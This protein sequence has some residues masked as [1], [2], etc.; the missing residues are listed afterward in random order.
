MTQLSPLNSSLSATQ[1]PRSTLRKLV[2]S[3]RTKAFL[4]PSGAWTNEIQDAAYF[5]DPLLARAAAEKFQLRDVELYY[6]FTDHVNS[7]Y[8]FTLPL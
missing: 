7:R 3:K 5:S 2:R 8:D 6:L 1:S 4:T